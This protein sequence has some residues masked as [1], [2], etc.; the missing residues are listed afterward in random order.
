MKITLFGEQPTVILQ[1][2][3]NTL[4]INPV[5]YYTRYKNIT[6]IIITKKDVKITEFLKENSNRFKEN[7]PLYLEERVWDF[8]VSRYGSL[9]FK[10]FI[11]HLIQ[12]NMSFSCGLAIKPYRIFKGTDKCLGLDF[13]TEFSFVDGIFLRKK[14]PNFSSFNFFYF[15]YHFGVSKTKTFRYTGFLKYNTKSCRL[16]HENGFQLM[17][18]GKTMDEKKFFYT[19]QIA[20]SGTDTKGFYIEGYAATSDLDRQN[21]IITPDA[22]KAAGDGL[23]SNDGRTVFF[24]H[25]Y[26]RCIGR[27][28]SADV[29][30]TGLLVKIYISEVEQ[31]LRTKISEGVISKFSIGGRILSSKIVSRTEAERIAGKAKSN[32][33]GKVNLITGIE[34]FEVSVVGLPANAKA[35]FRVH[36]SLDEAV[37]EILGGDIMGE[38]IAKESV[39]VS[40]EIK[41]PEKEAEKNIILETHTDITE[42]T[43]IAPTEI[44]S[45]VD[46]TVTSTRVDTDTG[47]KA[48]QIQEVHDKY[49]YTE[50]QMQKVK[51]EAEQAVASQKTEIDA[52]KKK[53]EELDLQKQNRQDDIQAEN[54]KLHEK[55]DALIKTVADLNSKVKE[56]P[57]EAVATKTAPIVPV[58]KKLIEDKPVEKSVDQIFLE[59]IQGKS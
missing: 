12:P 51:A 26:D 50:E 29:D 41:V 18:E 59:K 13:G 15:N 27:L 44:T 32:G 46:G 6:G 58:E 40:E 54:A 17:K 11:E 30:N 35:G 43:E 25:N 3:V 39:A 42:K 21:D 53:I 28:D 23:L 2:E 16:L 20:K 7:T 8:I 45:Q 24:N 49:V 34:L 37:N 10:N 22:L 47:E 19:C 9:C 14:E 52:L 36:K 1:D 56:I 55:L 31:E 33:A 48:S 4:L 57:V 38:E 5:K